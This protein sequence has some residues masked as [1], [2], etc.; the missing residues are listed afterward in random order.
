MGDA[1]AVCTSC[2]IT[3]ADVHIRQTYAIRKHMIE[4][5]DA[6]DGSFY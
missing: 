1:L 5:H 2:L 4:Y 3:V 6:I